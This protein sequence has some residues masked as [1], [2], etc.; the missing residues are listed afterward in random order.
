MINMLI[1][2]LIWIQTKY[3]WC[4]KNMGAFIST[5]TLYVHNVFKIKNDIFGSNEEKLSDADSIENA[6]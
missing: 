1:L 6:Q 3:T 5:G 2:P 4:P